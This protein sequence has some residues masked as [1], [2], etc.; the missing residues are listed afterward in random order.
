MSKGSILP[1]TQHEIELRDR[2]LEETNEQK[3]AIMY[4]ELQSLADDRVRI[5]SKRIRGN[6]NSN[7]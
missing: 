3:K 5:A 2:M 1:I 4:A 6:G 7:N